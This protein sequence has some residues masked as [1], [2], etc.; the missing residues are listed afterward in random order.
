[1]KIIIGLSFTLLVVVASVLPY[2]AEGGNRARGGT[3]ACGGAHLFRLGNS[4]IAITLYRFRNFNSNRT[5]TITQVT[6]FATDGTVLATLVPGSFPAGFDNVLGP[7][8]TT[9]FDTIDIFGSSPPGPPQP[10]LLQA[11]VQ[12]NADRSANILD[13]LT[14]RVDRARDA[15]SGAIGATRGRDH[16]ECV[17]LD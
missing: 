5:L 3:L 12:W 16:T 6:I 1:M 15:T 2:P 11:I 9:G 8:Q 10:G 4:E 17:S 14:V 7:N 13:G